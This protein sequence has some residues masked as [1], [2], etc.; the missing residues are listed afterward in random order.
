MVVLWYIKLISAG[1]WSALLRFDVVKPRPKLVVRSSGR[2]LCT[3]A[4]QAQDQAQQNTGCESYFK[5][6]ILVD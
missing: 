2:S 1:A 3:S 6:V 5:L 4:G